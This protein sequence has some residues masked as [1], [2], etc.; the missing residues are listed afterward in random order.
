MVIYYFMDWTSQTV[1][2]KEEYIQQNWQ[3]KEN[4]VF[5]KRR[6]MYETVYCSWKLRAWKK[7]CLIVSGK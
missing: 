3:A 2:K 5:D 7:M 1:K 6:R 4:V